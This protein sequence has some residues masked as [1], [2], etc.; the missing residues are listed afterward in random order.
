MLSFMMFGT[1]KLDFPAPVNIANPHICQFRRS[2]SR[3][4][5]NLDYIPEIGRQECAYSVKIGIRD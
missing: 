2:H 5:E 4:M 3:Q 1:I